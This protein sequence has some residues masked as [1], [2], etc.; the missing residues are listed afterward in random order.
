[1]NR[2]IKNPLFQWSLTIALL[3]GFLT[4]TLLQPESPLAQMS[5]GIQIL[6]AILLALLSLTGI[7]LGV[8]SW[9]RKELKVGWS[10]VVI[11]LNAVEFFLI[12]LHFSSLSAS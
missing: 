10:I 12:L 1:M 8:L 7:V 2:G 9:K 6:A 11:V 4:R 3:S 5:L